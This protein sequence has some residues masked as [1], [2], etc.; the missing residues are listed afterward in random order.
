M[1][2]KEL[3]S[4]F[5]R[6]FGEAIS[7]FQMIREG[8]RILVGLSGGKDSV[9]LLTALNLLRQKS[10]VAFELRA[11][12]IDCTDKNLDISPWAR[13]SEVMEIPLDIVRYP[14]FNILTQRGE[15]S[16]CSLCA[17]LRRGILASRAQELGCNCI[18]LGHHRDDAVETLLLNLFY[19][20][21]LKTFHPH[22]Y[23]SRSAMR[24][25]RP[26]VYVDEARI[27][28]EAKRLALPILDQQCPFA[29]DTG[30]AKVKEA[31]AELAGRFPDLKSN[32]MHALK[33]FKAED[34][35]T[36]PFLR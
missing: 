28:E 17:N 3:S 23:M 21:R 1:A 8:D 26:M 9:L 19:A 4:K 14:V 34:I 29:A 27:V 13:F 2:I 31:L 20:G 7:D 35:W 30:R 18:A 32:A 16:P 6:S 25:I 33:H 22:M 12:M 15:K 11:T 5:R 10:P 36:E 24:V